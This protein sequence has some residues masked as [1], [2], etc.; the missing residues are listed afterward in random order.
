M[1]QLMYNGFIWAACLMGVLPHTGAAGEERL[2]ELWEPEPAPNRGHDF[3]IVKA[4]GKPYDEDWERWSYPIGN[5][6]AGANIFGRT[7][8]ERIQIS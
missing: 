4:G 5:G 2:Y 8:T 3:D 1:K 6:Y 7:D